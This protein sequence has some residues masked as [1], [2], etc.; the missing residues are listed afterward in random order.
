VEFYG[1]TY[2]GYDI[3]LPCDLDLVGSTDYI[4]I[5]NLRLTIAWKKY[6][7]NPVTSITFS[8]LDQRIT[9]SYHMAPDGLEGKVNLLFGSLSL[10]KTGSVRNTFDITLVTS[11]A[12]LPC[13][14]HLEIEFLDGC[15]Y[16]WLDV[17]GD[18]TA[19]GSYPNWYRLESM[20]CDSTESVLGDPTYIDCEVGEAYKIQNG[21][22]VSLDG[23]IEL[24]SNPPK[25]TPG[26]NVI[27]HTENITQLDVT[28]RWW[29]I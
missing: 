3:P 5:T 4:V 17:E 23:Y 18:H 20:V 28:P 16:V 7:S 11:N 24:G 6:T 19:W 12:E 26:E 8:D 9:A 29:R 10:R 2:F 21:D 1:E 14:G 15:F 25:L 27:T 13:E 22:Y